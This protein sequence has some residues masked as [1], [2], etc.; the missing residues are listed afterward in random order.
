[1]ARM[2]TPIART[3]ETLTHGRF[4]LQT[5]A[6]GVADALLVGFHGYGENADRH[7]DQL[8]RLPGVER[9][10]V[11]SVQAL[12]RFYTRTDDVV[13]SWMTRE[14]RE[15]AIADNIA[16]VDRVVAEIRNHQ[17]ISRVVYLG[18]SQGVAMAF[19]AAVRGASRCR[20]VIALGGDIPPELRSEARWP[21]DRA[22][23][24]RGTEDTWYT[25]EKL[26]A[27]VAFLQSIGVDVHAAVVQGGHEWTDGFRQS[28]ADF[29]RSVLG[30]PL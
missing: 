10:V 13:A 18:F 7:M 20:A 28:A 8:Q 25:D 21:I 11:A 12:H 19:R 24:G 9:W 27:D 2:T 16:Y 17:A 23:I 14:D 22:L 1:M 6:T 29:L 26:H 5:P 3:I 4:L 30:G 15:L